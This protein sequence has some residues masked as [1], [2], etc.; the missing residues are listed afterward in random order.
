M[1]CLMYAHAQGCPWNSTLCAI[2]A[3]YGHLDCLAYAHENGCP[4]DR[5]TCEYADAHAQFQ[6]LAYAYERGRPVITL[7]SR[8]RKYLDVRERSATRVASAYRAWIA[9]R[10]ADVDLVLA[11]RWGRAAPRP[12]R[13]IQD[14]RTM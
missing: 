3:K 14:E 4:W 5:Q 13:S 9:R 12:L 6:C 1:H 8:A 7:S 11:G 10:H 2:A